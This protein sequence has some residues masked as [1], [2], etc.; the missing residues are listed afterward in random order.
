MLLDGRVE[1]GAYTTRAAFSRNLFAVQPLSRH[2]GLTKPADGSE[3]GYRE[4]AES[5]P[6]PNT[7]TGPIK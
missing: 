5:E 6:R 7:T 3:L 1:S 4:G 2:V